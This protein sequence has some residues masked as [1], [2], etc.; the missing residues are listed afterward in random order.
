ML[1]EQV[2]IS[3]S[4]LL[5]I[6]SAANPDGALLYLYLQGGNALAAAE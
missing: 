5:K 6:L 4:D 2:T 3:R 1:T